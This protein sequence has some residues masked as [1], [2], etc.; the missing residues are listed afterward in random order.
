ME[1][2]SKR[3]IVA[4]TC[5]EQARELASRLRCSPIT[6]QLLLNRGHS[7]FDA[8]RAFLYPSLKSLHEP[9]LIA[10]LRSAADRIA[11]A[12]R[13]GETIVV[14][15]DYDVD[16]ITATAILW[17]AFTMLGGRVETYVP[18]RVDEGYGLNEDAVRAICG[19][20][21]A[22]SEAKDEVVE[23]DLIREAASD[24]LRLRGSDDAEKTN[25]RNEPSSSASPL[26]ERSNKKLIVTVDCGVTALSAAKAAKACG[27][28]LI[29]T[30]HH[31]WK[32]VS[33]ND[34][35]EPKAD[36][37][38]CHSVVHPRLAFGGVEYGNPNLCGAGVAFKLAWATGLALS[39]A[40]RVEEKFRNFLVDATALAALGTIADVV[41]LTGENRVLAAFGLGGLQATK[42]T[43]IRALIRSAGLEGKN[44]DSYHVGFLLGP[45]LNACGR[46][47]HAKLAIELLTSASEERAIEIADY[48]ES[49]N[50][51]RQAV[52]RKIV[53][54]ALFQVNDLNE[55]A[56]VLASKDWHAGVIG[57]VASRL[58]ER[59]H[60]PTVLIALNDEGGSG[61]G[62]SISGFHLANA[63]NVCT[64]HLVSHGGHAMAAGLK[65]RP[66]NFDAFREA[67]IAHARQ[68]LTNEQLRPSVKLEAVVQL[69]EMSEGL[70]D[71]L[72]RLGPFG[73]GNRKPLLC[74]ENVE[75]AA[76]PK[77]VGKT[78]D[79]LSLYLKQGNTRT[80]AIAF[81]KGDW[82]D[83]LFAG[84]II[85]LAAEPSINEF[86]GR[87]SVELEV[88]DL[89]M[90]GSGVEDDEELAT[91]G[92]A[93]EHP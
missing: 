23:N 92:H 49:Q 55:P 85:D 53:D 59:F 40:A 25:E 51:E 3:W 4:E 5:E 11:E 41:P 33:S 61:S 74:F 83:R 64:E 19:G 56:I 29:V 81:G 79:H 37:P 39:G 1:P 26:R 46:L 42:L 12:I 84:S 27:V 32:T 80:R 68:T 44:L 78:G 70:V 66:E 21:N 35:S 82:C 50:R 93:K 58:V 67:F 10:N 45:R 43:G 86:N 30:D 8:C 77:R 14:Y 47:G 52:E 28:D 65:I 15:G 36:L 18:H 16:G 89:R 69:A 75:L 90:T 72:K 60:R 9:H 20:S 87:R 6:A 57:I 88:K 7:S 63:L 71:E 34:E 91:T 48:L 31:E 76:A 17:H 24:R 13:G 2:L 22:Q 54:E 73:M 62:R 38:D